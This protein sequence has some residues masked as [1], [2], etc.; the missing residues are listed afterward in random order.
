M[1]YFQEAAELG[2]E[3]TQFNSGIYCYNNQSTSIDFLE[4]FEYFKQ[5]LH[6]NYAFTQLALRIFLDLSR[7]IP[8]DQNYS[9]RYLSLMVGSGIVTDNE[10]NHIHR[11]ENPIQVLSLSVS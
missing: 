8:R 11:I 2:N 1:R 7:G 10:S 5:S 6:Q 3:I 9:R 4:A